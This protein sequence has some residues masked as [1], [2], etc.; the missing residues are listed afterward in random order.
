[1]ED[2]L[3]HDRRELHLVLLFLL[4]QKYLMNAAKSSGG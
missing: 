4:Y 2:E 3:F 1:V